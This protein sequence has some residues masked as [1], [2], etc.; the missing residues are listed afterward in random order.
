MTEGARA[1][2]GREKENVCLQRSF[3]FTAVGVGLDNTLTYGLFLHLRLSFE[4]GE[5]ITVESQ[6]KGLSA[7]EDIGS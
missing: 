3:Y 6:V 5:P 4:H 2:S 7:G 1:S